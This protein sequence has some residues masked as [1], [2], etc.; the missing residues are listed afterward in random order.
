MVRNVSQNITKY[1][2]VFAFC[3]SIFNVYLIPIYPLKYPNSG[4]LLSVSQLEE[5]TLNHHLKT[6]RQ[7]LP[8]SSKN[9]T[10]SHQE[11][12]TG[13]SGTISLT[14]FLRPLLKKLSKDVIY[15]MVHHLL[16]RDGQR[17]KLPFVEMPLT[18]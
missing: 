4:S 5:L 6:L 14:N 18:L 15:T 11:T 17:V 1:Y 8:V 9:S 16:Q 10:M 3:K 12:K 7:N 2:C 13:M